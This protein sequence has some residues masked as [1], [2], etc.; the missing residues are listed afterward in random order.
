MHSVSSRRATA[1]LRLRVLVEDWCSVTDYSG[2]F[3][4]ADERGE[5]RPQERLVGLFAGLFL[6]R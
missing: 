6:L 4:F 2:S 5:E 3:W 1:R